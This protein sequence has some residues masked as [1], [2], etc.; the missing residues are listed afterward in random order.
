MVMVTRYFEYDWISFSEFELTVLDL[1]RVACDGIGIYLDASRHLDNRVVVV[2]LLNDNV[3]RRSLYDG[4]VCL[5]LGDDCLR[6][7]GY[8]FEQVIDYSVVSVEAVREAVVGASLVG[9]GE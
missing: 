9:G 7:I 8:G 1:I 3:I 6:V 4:I 5:R 2:L